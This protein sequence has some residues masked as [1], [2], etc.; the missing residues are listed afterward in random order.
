[1]AE[2]KQVVPGLTP[3]QRRS[4]P[5]FAAMRAFEAIGT[6]GGIRR[7]AAAMS[8]DHAAVSR[9]LR[10]LEQWAG[11]PLADR[12]SG[13]LTREGARFHARICTALAELASASAE[14]THRNDNRQL[15][16]WSVPG[17]A[18]QWLS[19]RLGGFS[20]LHPGVE[21]EVQPTDNI[22]RF[23]SHEADALI[24]YVIDGEAPLV[25]DADTRSVEILRPQVIPVASPEFLDRGLKLDSPADLLD[26]PLLH[27]A[28]SSQ[29]RRWFRAHDIDV[30]DTLVGAKLW[31]AHMTVAAAR[32]G[33]GIA[34]SNRLLIADDLQAGT[35]VEVGNFAPVILGGYV[36]T[37]RRER[38]QEP[39]IQ[40]FRRWLEKAVA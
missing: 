31:H 7:A 36:F 19:G 17:I 28:S 13:G 39:V 21:L 30:E 25:L 11:V 18:S 27:E 16:V 2:D 15:R 14:L 22:P 33:Q 29:W 8:L 37:A 26:A 23:A 12:G 4:L 40:G 1:M 6:C 10:S 24:S 5:P 38:W 20:E 3:A 35:L 32:R 34:L 9:H